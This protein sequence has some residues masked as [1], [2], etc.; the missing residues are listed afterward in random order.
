M[1][2][3]YISVESISYIFIFFI[4]LC[5]NIARVENG[6]HSNFC[7]NPRQLLFTAFCTLCIE[8]YVCI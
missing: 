7:D 2:M 1:H 5:S 3:D 6:G 4:I 8:T